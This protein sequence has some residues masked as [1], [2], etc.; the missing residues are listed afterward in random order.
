MRRRSKRQRAAI[1]LLCETAVALSLA[2]M[3]TQQPRN[4][5]TRTT[6]GRSARPCVDTALSE[7]EAP[8]MD[9]CI[10]VNDVTTP[11]DKEKRKDS[12][13]Q[14]CFEAAVKRK[15]NIP[16]GYS[17]VAVLLVRWH[18]SIDEY[19]AGHTEEVSSVFH[20]F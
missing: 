3:D 7:P 17:K 18:E 4:P 15:L 8:V 20:A 19:A 16:S 6:T 1:A 9:A 2:S 5:E 10:T 13:R 11:D 14:A 12:E